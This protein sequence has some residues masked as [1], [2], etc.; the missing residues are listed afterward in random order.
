MDYQQRY[1]QITG[2]HWLKLRPS[3]LSQDWTEREINFLTISRGTPNPPTFEHISRS[4]SYMGAQRSAAE[5]KNK[6]YKLFPSNS[7]VN[8]AVEHL[9]DMR[10]HWPGLYFHPQKQVSTDS[11]GH[12]QLIALHIVWPW[13]KDI[14]RTLSPSIFCDATYETTV[15]HYKVVMF[16]TFDGNNQHRPLM[17]SFIMNSTST[18]WAT[19][20]DIFHA[21]YD[22]HLVL[23]ILDS[24]PLNMYASGYH[25]DFASCSSS[26]VTKKE[27]YKRDCGYHQCLNTPS[28]I[29]VHYMLNGMFVIINVPTDT[30]LVNKLP[31]LGQDVCNLQKDRR[32][33][34]SDTKK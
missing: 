3:Y 9:R 28:N 26:R 11:D 1:Y 12:P 21:R 25:K 23:F 32:H 33:S 6:W 17:C 5:C 14:M 24:F 18:Q 27:Q 2:S 13:S 31:K 34:R 19:L 8:N 29:F 10:K 22:S 4:L 16:S 15:Y 7:D 20:F 30:F